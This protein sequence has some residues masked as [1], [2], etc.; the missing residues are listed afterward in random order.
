M[1]TGDTGSNNKRENTFETSIVNWQLGSYFE[2]GCPSFVDVGAFEMH[3]DIGSM[4]DR[5]H[6]SMTSDKNAL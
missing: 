4:I 6:V 1:H 3:Q 2:K 5:Y